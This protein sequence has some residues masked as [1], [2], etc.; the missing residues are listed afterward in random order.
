MPDNTTSFNVSMINNSQLVYEVYES[1][2]CVGEASSSTKANINQCVS[3][4]NDSYV[5]QLSEGKLF[6]VIDYD[7][8]T[9]CKGKTVKN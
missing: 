4:S 6:Y 5:F 1:K 7:N 8:S 9:I 2:N 3:I